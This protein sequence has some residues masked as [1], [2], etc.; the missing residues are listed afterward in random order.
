MPSLRFAGTAKI[1]GTAAKITLV[2]AYNGS[3][4][5]T[6]ACSSTPAKARAIQQACGQVLRTFKVSKLFT[7]GT[8][9]VYRKPGVSF[10]YPPTFAETRQGSHFGCRRCVLWRAAVGLD[11]V[12][13]VDVT[14]NLENTAVTRQNLPEAKPYVT[15][16]I[17][18]VFGHF[19]GRMLAGPQA[20]M[21]GGMPGLRY[22]GIGY[23]YGAAVKA[24]FVVVFNG[25]TI[26]TISCTSTPVQARSVDRACAEVL[27]TFKV[28]RPSR[29]A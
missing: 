23:V 15:R 6:I 13:T 3:T 12:N 16:L 20:I 29:R 27:R 18:R 5:Y 7:A 9:L 2:R 1:H 14:A 28:T 11:R 4:E 21:V 25:T 10:D 8:A 24:T 17:R 26:Y 19:G 22:R